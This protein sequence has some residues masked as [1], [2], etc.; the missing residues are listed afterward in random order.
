MVDTHPAICRSSS[1]AV[2]A[3]LEFHFRS[4]RDRLLRIAK[5]GVSVAE[6]SLVL[7]K[8]IGPDEFLG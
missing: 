6:P 2:A 3:E 4:A 7:F 8:K 5:V 1:G